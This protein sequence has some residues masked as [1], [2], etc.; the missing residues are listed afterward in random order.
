MSENIGAYEETPEAAT[1]AEAGGGRLL[2]G[3]AGRGALRWVVVDLALPLDEA[4][5]RLDL[6]PLSAVALGRALSGAALLR[7]IA[8]KVPSRVTLEIAGDGPLG[9]V[10]AEAETGGGVRGMVGNPRLVTPED[11]S[12]SLAPWIGNGSLRVTRES[13]GRRYASEVTLVTSE[14]GLDLAH[15]LEQSEQIRSAVLVGV[16]PATTGIAAAGGLIVEALPGTPEEDVERLE[17]NLRGLEGVSSTL[18]TG[19]LAA[20]ERTVLEG[21]DVELLEDRPLAYRCGCSRERLGAQLTALA[22]RELDSL[23]EDDGVCRAECSFCAARYEFTA[24][25]LSA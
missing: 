12:M 13:E 17:G 9:R 1:A 11:G 15:Y 4:R 3:L 20:L 5:R 24:A 8:L 19:G 14:I 22:R 23:L 2:S 16:L 10:V 25:E 21:F 18:A 7:R 6:S